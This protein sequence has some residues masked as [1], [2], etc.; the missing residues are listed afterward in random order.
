MPKPI[1][2]RLATVQ[3]SADLFLGLCDFWSKNSA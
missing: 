1:A 3:A 2:L